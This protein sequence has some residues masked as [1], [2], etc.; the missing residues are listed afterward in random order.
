MCRS[1]YIYGGIG[2]RRVLVLKRK[3]VSG[4]MLT[5]LLMGILTLAFNI[6]PVKASGTIYIRADGSVDPPTAPIISVDN[7]T[8]TFTGN[9]FDSIVVERDNTIIDGAGYRLQGDGMERGIDLSGRKNI[10]VR[11]MEI[12]TFE[13]GIYAWNSSNNII[14]SN[15]VTANYQYGIGFGLSSNNIISG[16]SITADDHYGILLAYAS[17]NNSI[18]GN[19]VTNNSL[20]GIFL[21]EAKNNRIYENNIENNGNGVRI[22]LSSNNNIYHNNLIN[23]TKQVSTVASLDFWDH[24]YP[25]GGNYWSDYVGVDVKS[26]PNQD[27]LESDGI[28][29]MPYIINVDNV[30]HYPLMNPYGAPP[31]PT[32]ALT[33]TTT[34][35]GTTNPAPRTYS[36]TANSTV[37]VA[38]IQ[39]ANYLFDHWELDSVDVGSANPYQVLM[40]KNHTLKAVFSPIAPLSAS[41]SPLSASINVGQSLT[42][43]STV[44]GGTPPYSYQWYLN[45][46]PVSGAT[47]SSWTFASTTSGIYYVCLKVTDA[48]GNT[49]QSETTRITVAAVPVGGYSLPINGQTTA[50]PLTPYLAVM[51]ILPVVFTVIRRKISNRKKPRETSQS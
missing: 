29:D 7:V 31:P 34:A 35:G 49:T 32:Y 51:A 41:I 44:A 10:T 1:C 26:G 14:C 5:L 16:N 20:S 40:D 33:I 9:I 50:N 4:I 37:Q 13:Y 12:K 30:D 45:G 48:K 3:A 15:N 39:D 23:N 27:L 22:M 28:G 17:S 36:Y 46:N 25:S 42:F 18:A 38:A 24:G 21:Y 47:S 6:Q 19:N 8:Y 2:E 11:N 43:T